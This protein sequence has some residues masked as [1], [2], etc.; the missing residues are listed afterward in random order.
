MRMGSQ[1]C[2]LSF[3]SLSP[4][5]AASLPSTATSIHPRREQRGGGVKVTQL[6]S[7]ESKAEQ[8]TRGEILKGGVAFL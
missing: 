5:D 6:H 2:S 7:A 3:A 8:H 1:L 4:G